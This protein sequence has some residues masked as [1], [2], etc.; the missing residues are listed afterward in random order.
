MEIDDGR[1]P[2]RFDGYKAIYQVLTRSNNM[3]RHIKVST[4][5]DLAYFRQIRGH[6][7]TKFGWKLTAFELVLDFMDIK[8]H[9]KLRRLLPFSKKPEYL[10]VLYLIPI[11]RYTQRIL[12]KLYILKG[13]NSYPNT[14]PGFTICFYYYTTNDSHYIYLLYNIITTNDISYTI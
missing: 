7:S 11:I 10:F 12:K 5:P 8:P 4:K 1:T 6:N 14:T 2:S 9:T 3:Y 13:G